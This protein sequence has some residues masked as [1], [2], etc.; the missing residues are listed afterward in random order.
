[1][2][3][4]SIVGIAAILA[5]AS[6]AQAVTGFG[7]S[8]LSVPLLG[9]IVGPIEAVVGSSIV[10][11][12]LNVLIVFRDHGSVQWKTARIVLVAGIAGLPLGLL[13]LRLLPSRVLSMFI[14]VVVMAGALAIWRGV[15]VSPGRASVAA[16]GVVSGVLTTATGINGPP[17]AAAFSAMDLRPRQ[18]RATLAAIFAIV[19]VFGVA[20]FA[21]TGQI[22]DSSLWVA[23]IGVPAI[24]VGGYVGNKVFSRISNEKVFRYLVLCGLALAAIAI[25]AKALF[26]Y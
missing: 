13:L 21:A 20:G 16:A 12:L 4:P 7:F 2:D 15:R 14:A 23:L 6:L 5:I 1:M 9:I 24:A 19:G 22:S 10:V 3:S 11:L 18:F 26:A 25:L 17:L 8:L